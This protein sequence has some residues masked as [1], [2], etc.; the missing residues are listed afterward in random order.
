MCDTDFSFR[1]DYSTVIHAQNSNQ[2]GVSVLTV[3]RREKLHQS[4]G[5]GS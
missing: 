2:P 1:V 4:V 3:H 5:P